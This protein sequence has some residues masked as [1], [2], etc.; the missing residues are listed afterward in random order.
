[1]GGEN[2]IPFI[3]KRMGTGSK[4]WSVG[5]QLKQKALFSHFTDLP[6]ILTVLEIQMHKL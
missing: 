3:Q 6:G 5:E 1:V 4:F 2:N